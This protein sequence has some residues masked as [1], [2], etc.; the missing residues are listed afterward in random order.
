[1]YTREYKYFHSTTKTLKCR[2]YVH[3]KPLYN[4]AFVSSMSP[5]AFDTQ[6]NYAGPS[7]LFWALN[8]KVHVFLQLHF[9]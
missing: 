4:G 1:M 7:S 9:G 8:V 6:T 3:I 5:R 2:I